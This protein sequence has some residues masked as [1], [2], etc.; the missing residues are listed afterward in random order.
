MVS[1]HIAEKNPPRHI[2]ERHLYREGRRMPIRQRAAH[3]TR[4]P[5]RTPLYEEKIPEEFAPENSPKRTGGTCHRPSR[6]E[7]ET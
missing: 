2:Y 5:E 7:E 6:P 1:H 4:D 3:K